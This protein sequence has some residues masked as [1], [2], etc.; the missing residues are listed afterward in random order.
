M[1]RL[2]IAVF[3]HL[4]RGHI[5]SVL[6]LCTELVG[7][8]HRVTYPTN[9]HFA[10]TIQDSGA[11]PILIGTQRMPVELL[12]ESRKVMALQGT[13][14]RVK[15]TDRKWASYAFSDA[16]AF[17][18]RV[19]PFY[20]TDVPDLIL[21]DRY[22]IPGRIFSRRHD[23]PAAQMTTHFAFYNNL[24][25]RKNGVC[26]NSD[27]VI[28][29]AQELDSFLSSHGITAAN[30]YWHVENLNI[31]FIPKEFQHNI[32][33]FDDRFC[34]A[35]ALLNRH[36]QPLWKT[37]SNGKPV[38]LI[39]G[40]TLPNDDAMDYT[41]YF[42]TLVDALSGEPYHCILSLGDGDFSQP[43]PDNFEIN[44][45]AS[46][47]DILPHAA[48]F[49]GHGGAT[50]TLEAIYNGVPAL[51][52]P[53]SE[54]CDEIAYRVEELGIGTRLSMES[55]SVATIRSIVSSM[56]ENRSLRTRV[57]AMR[58]VFSRSGGAE[59]AADRI[60]DMGMRAQSAQLS[61]R[62]SPLEGRAASLASNTSSQSPEVGNFSGR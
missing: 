45:R 40:M 30:N 55:L 46:H 39:S 49:I 36:Y 26:G 24:A 17:L 47:L 8:G 21:Y 27:E 15:A 2:H 60:E 59:L 4:A 52:I 44:R 31:H 25:G 62:P 6:P 14:P 13:D 12:E 11:E 22:H 42:G 50:S 33:Y 34:F 10:Q 53:R 28:A 43:V 29:W 7:R 3:T 5:Y 16:E 37:S 18:Q 57:A 32:E 20:Q 41:D 51:L 23:I 1:N 9:D 54:L 19:E 61:H 35:G 56:L 48:L 38:I 58:D